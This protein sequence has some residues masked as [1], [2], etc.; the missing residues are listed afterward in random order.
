VTVTPDPADTT[1]PGETP[2]DPAA[3]STT[4]PTGGSAPSGSST[5]TAA[6]GPGTSPDPAPEPPAPAPITK[7]GS[8]YYCRIITVGK[9]NPT[10]PD[11][12]QE[13]YRDDQYSDG[14]IET[15]DMGA[16]KGI[17]ITD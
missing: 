2:T 13:Q 15:V 16:T 10:D 8:S 3:D 12:R 17:C 6:A 7:V 4:A 9:V 11:T 5:P 1:A 14:H